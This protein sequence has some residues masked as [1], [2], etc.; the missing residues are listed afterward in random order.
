MLIAQVT[1]IH[2]GFQPDDPAELNRKR[3]DEVVDAL[4]ALT[5]QPDLLLAT[6]DLTEHGSLASYQTLKLITERLPFPVHFALGNH[7]ERSNFRSVFPDVPVL[8]SGHV[9]YAFVHGPLRFV[10]LDTLE[11]G[12]HGGAFS[13]EQATWLDTTLAEDTSPTMLVL[14]HPPIETGNGWMT[15][16]LDSPW[17]R[18]LAA[19]VER[20]PHVIRMVTGHLHR[21]I[22]TGWHGT[23]LAVCPSAAPQVA[24]DFR[25]IDPEAPDGRDMIVAEAPGFALHYWTGR[26]LVTHYGSSGDHPVLARYNARMQPTV[27]HILA[28]RL[29]GH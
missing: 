2:L 25:E 28:E 10:V 6:G 26:D 17:V 16:D 29:G 14:H 22:V 1:D 5:P 24:I 20:H 11:E 8:P 3:F 15:E 19:V 21:A 4:L 23:T 12:H 9:Q 27:Q 7:D 18:R 13:A